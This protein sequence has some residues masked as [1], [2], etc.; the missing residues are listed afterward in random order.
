MSELFKGR[1]LYITLNVI[2]LIVTVLPL[3]FTGTAWLG[4][5]LSSLY[6]VFAVRFLLIVAIIA[7]IAA[8][9]LASKNNDAAVVAALIF[10][11]IGGFAGS[12]L[13]GCDKRLSIQLRCI[14]IIM[15][16]MAVISP[17]AN[18]L[19]HQYDVL[20]MLM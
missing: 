2:M 18:I 6:F 19:L 5:L 17:A 15:L 10:G 3:L 7:N 11:F 14:F 16:W 9:F 4:F 20:P 12:F 13:S 8:F 1:K